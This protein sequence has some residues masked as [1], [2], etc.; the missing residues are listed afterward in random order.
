MSET[1]M[2][3]SDQIHNNKGN[4]FFQ[5]PLKTNFQVS[6][7]ERREVDEMQVDKENEDK[8]IKKSSTEVISFQQKNRS[9]AKDEKRE[10]KLKL[11]EG[12]NIKY[13][14]GNNHF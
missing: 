8:V 2:I 6:Q 7:E 14:I 12:S 9:V 10:K 11:S 3:N 4:S 13:L 1:K 5:S